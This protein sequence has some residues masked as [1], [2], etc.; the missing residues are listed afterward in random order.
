[1][2]KRIIGSIPEDRVVDEPEWLDVESLAEVEITSEDSAH[3]IESALLPGGAPGWRA[4][5]P[6]RQ[7]IRLRFSR[8]Q[9]LRQIRLRFREPDRERTQEY[10]LRWSADDGQTWREIVRQQWNF[11]PLSTTCEMED[12]HVDLPAVSMLELTII[13]DIGGGDAL[14]SLAQL[15]LA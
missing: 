6:G 1:M 3:P 13:P 5:G 9:P 8:P 11:S 10:S 12:H 2:R 7:T 15:R 4:A 14:A